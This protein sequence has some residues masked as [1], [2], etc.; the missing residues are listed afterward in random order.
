MVSYGRSCVRIQVTWDPCKKSVYCVGCHRDQKLMPECGS[1]VLRW[2]NSITGA[3]SWKKPDVVTYEREA[4]ERVKWQEPTTDTLP[5]AITCSECEE[6]VAKVVCESCD[7]PFCI[8]CLAETHQIGNMAKHYMQIIDL[9]AMNLP[10]NKVKLCNICDV[11]RAITRCTLCDDNYCLACFRHQHAKGKM[12]GHKNEEIKGETSTKTLLSFLGFGKKSLESEQLV[13][14]CVAVADRRGWKIYKR[15]AE[16]EAEKARTAA[17]RREKRE[18]ARPMLQSAFSMFDLDGSGVLSPA[19]LKVL[20]HSVLLEPV[21]DQELN[22]A[23]KRM[24]FNGDGEISFEEFLDW[25][26]AFIRYIVSTYQIDVE[27]DAVPEKNA[28]RVFMEKFLPAWNEGKLDDTYYMDGF[29]FKY[30]NTFFTKAWDDEKKRFRY[31]DHDTNDWQYNHPEKTEELK[32]KLLEI[33]NKYDRNGKGT[34]ESNRLHDLLIIELNEPFT[35]DEVQAA[36]KMLDKDEDGNIKFVDFLPWIVEEIDFLQR[37]KRP[38]S[39]ANQT[40]PCNGMKAADN[41]IQ[42]QKPDKALPPGT[43]KPEK[44]SNK[45][46]SSK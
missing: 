1:G 25:K 32:P 41:K 19:E 36:A 20:L 43:V 5:W 38:R 28:Q 26:E 14:C 16:E 12:A 35:D 6:E 18:A 17:R 39:V 15:L 45:K 11:Q 27:E 3:I 8:K 46:K 7:R 9:E 4:E 10:E 44:V 30:K 13:P 33:F 31:R 42:L 2:Y 24:D 23:V 34:V 40:N 21:T 22:E 37:S 29:E